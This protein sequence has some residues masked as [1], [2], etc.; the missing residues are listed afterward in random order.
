MKGFILMISMTSSG[1]GFNTVVRKPFS[2]SP[3]NHPQSA[4]PDQ[5]RKMRLR[6]IENHSD[7]EVLEMENNVYTNLQET[8]HAKKQEGIE[9]LR[10][11]QSRGLS[12][13]L[14]GIRDWAASLAA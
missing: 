9:R 12:G 7:D 4:S 8:Q 10:N 5:L 1:N 13:L 2:K 3:L 14:I 11:K 6:N